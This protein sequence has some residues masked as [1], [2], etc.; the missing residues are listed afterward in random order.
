MWRT[1][2]GLSSLQRS[3]RQRENRKL[4]YYSLYAWGCP[5]ILATFCVIMES[6]S[7]RLPEIWRPEFQLGDCWFSKKETLMI[8]FYNWRS[9]CIISSVCFSISASM[10]IARYEKETRTRLS[11][12]DSK[13]YNDNK[14]WLQLYLR[15][16]I[17]QF[18]LLIIQWVIRVLYLF[19]YIPDAIGYYIDVIDIPQHICTFIIFVCKK[20]VIIILLKRFG[21]KTNGVS[22]STT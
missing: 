19:N 21:C 4:I 8:Y 18:V 2:R 1:F 9:I 10:N 22:S 7:S 15:L 11:D 20:K 12:S 16:F 14:K 17:V 6:V 5:F 13:Q 3:I